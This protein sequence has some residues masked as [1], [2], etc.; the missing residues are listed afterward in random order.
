M[1]TK[2]FSNTE[3]KRYPFVRFFNPRSASAT[4]AKNLIP[5]HPKPKQKKI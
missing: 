1:Y 2:H 5:K 4:I 3:Q